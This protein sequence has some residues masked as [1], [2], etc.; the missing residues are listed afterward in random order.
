VSHSFEAAGLLTV[1]VTAT[2]KDGGV[3][4]LAS[5]EINVIQPVDIDVKP[6]N[7]QNKI[8]FKSQGVIPVAIFT[9]ADFD[10]A[11]IDGSTVALAGVAAD[12]FALE[13]VDGD[14]DVDMISHF[15]TQD[16]LAAL[17]LDLDPGEDE[18]VDAE[19]TGETVDEVMI[20][21]FD[22]VD[23]FLPGNGKAKGKK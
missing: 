4:D 7:D 9:T 2:D 15:R 17:G 23:F 18:T 22:T 5:F 10:A 6:G 20:Q 16:L 8:N 21:G 14:G 11:T 1:T 12:H 19:L 3:S 13:D